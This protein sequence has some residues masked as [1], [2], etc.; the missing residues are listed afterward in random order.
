MSRARGVDAVS[1]GL[2]IGYAADRALGD[3]R[4][5]HPVAGFGRVAARLEQQVYA[6]TRARGLLHEVALV[7]VAAGL[8][9]LL[10][11]LPRPAQTLVV[12][13]T[14]WTVLG[15]GS[16]DREA[17]EVHRHLAAHDLGAARL[18]IRHLVGRDPSA[19]SADEIAR[20]CVESVAENC[21]D[22]V[23]APL[24]WGAV[25]GPPGLLVYRAVNTLD[26]M[27]GHR[28]PRY[29][30]F[31]WAAARLDDLANWLPARLTVAAAA[32]ST[33]TASGARRV[34]A[35]VRRDSGAHPSPN[36]GPVESAFAAC[37]EVQLGGSNT[38]AGV[39]EDR[40]RLG[41]GPPVTPGDIPRTT[42][43][44]RRISAICLA[45]L[46]LGRIIL[47]AATPGPRPRH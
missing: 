30:E 31:G 24:F 4:R 46:V 45:A 44:Q 42:A 36:A 6:P 40:G 37:L 28:T 22:A 17:E 11:R 26:A 21:T 38:Y 34:C 27:V 13:A 19:L 32:A 5:G 20:A 3:P 47:R 29:R 9:I 14:T 35:V 33:G 10:G 25:A 2:L 15:G 39:A 43:R 1:V 12:A 16:L 23:V 7:T 8:G 41:D 18:Q